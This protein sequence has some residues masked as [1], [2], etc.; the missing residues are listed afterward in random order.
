MNDLDSLFNEAT[1]VGNECECDYEDDSE[2][3]V[4]DHDFRTISIPSNKKLLGVT[5]DSRVNT[6]WFI[7]PRY[8]NGID[9][10]LF[11]LR[12]NYMNAHNEGDL[13]VVQNPIIGDEFIKFCWVVGHHA[14]LY[15]GNVSFIVCAKLFVE[16]SEPPAI[17]REYNTALHTLPVVNGLEVDEI[18]Y[19]ANYDLIEQFLREIKRGEE[20]EEWYRLTI[21]NATSA[22]NSKIAAHDSEVNSKTSETNSAISSNLA[23]AAS[24]EAVI[25]VDNIK[26]Y[27]YTMGTASGFVLLFH[28][29]GA[30]IGVAKLVAKFNPNQ[31]GSGT[32]SQDNVRPF[33]KIT[34]VTIEHTGSG[35]N[36]ATYTMDWTEEAP[37]MYGGSVNLVTGILSPYKYYQSY[38][39]EELVGPWLS[40][41]N[42]YVA[43]RI[44]SLGAEVIDMGA[45]ADDI[46]LMPQAVSTFFEMNL[47]TSN[48]NLME[49]DYFT[50]YGNFRLG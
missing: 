6:L 13:Y 15:N 23:Q 33:V 49:L 18:V 29:G 22:N 38:N 44:P 48:A 25:A 21:E 2:L 42:E 41:Q 37:A 43:G 10:S 50:K 39:G 17:A 3:L 30:G 11:E 47:F 28:D 34:G 46:H 5:N 16:G 14:C 45:M 1:V 40:S 8:Y 20:I 7:A 31:S 26:K 35:G 36:F 24:A 12:I 27:F 19:E 9:M 4:I 32:P